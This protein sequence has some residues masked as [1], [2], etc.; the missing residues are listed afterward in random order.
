MGE[1]RVVCRVLVGK[2]KWKR[3]MGRPRRRWVDNIRMDLQEVGCVHTDWIGL[4]QVRD[5]W[6]TFVSEV[7][8]IRVPWNAGNFLT[9]CKPVSFS[10]R[11]L[12]HGVSKQV[13]HVRTTG[14]KTPQFRIH[15]SILRTSIVVNNSW[16]SIYNLH[17]I[18][19]SDSPAIWL[20]TTMRPKK[21]LPLV[22]GMKL[23]EGCHSVSAVLFPCGPLW[24]VSP[25]LLWIADSCLVIFTTSIP[26][27]RK[28]GTV[29]G[30]LV[31]CAARGNPFLLWLRRY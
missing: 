21:E 8:N 2:P 1:E 24:S 14:W 25:I 27:N 18:I 11:A 26:A 3:P 17:F 29:E 5:M 10:R 23:L 15:S 22:V 13:L 20:D 28:A 9:S 19:D 30:N 12:R 31:K 6:R 16:F 4:A 7:M